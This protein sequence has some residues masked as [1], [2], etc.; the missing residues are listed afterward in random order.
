MQREFYFLDISKHRR[1]G[2]LHRMK[3]KDFL[4]AFLPFAAMTAFAEQATG[5]KAAVVYYW[6][7]GNTREFARK[8]AAALG[9]EAFA[10]EPKT[11]YTRKY[12]AVVEQAKR[13]LNAMYKPP[14][15]KLPDISDCGI[16]FLGTPNWWGTMSS[17]VRTFVSEADLSGKVIAPFITHKGSRW[18]NYLTD[19]KKMAPRAKLAQGMELWSDSP[20]EKSATAKISEWAKKTAI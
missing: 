12:G 17:P 6:W 14:L 10:L 19:L 16:L 8:I 7:R 18:G 3:R 15:K 1:Y 5:K 2:A 4:K 13:E 20:K 9:V 11:P